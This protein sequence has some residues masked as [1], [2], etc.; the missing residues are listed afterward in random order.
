MELP[1]LAACV[2]RSAR[3]NPERLGVDRPRIRDGLHLTVLD[4]IRDL[5]GLG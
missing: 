4:S 2:G 5:R 3:L 1:R